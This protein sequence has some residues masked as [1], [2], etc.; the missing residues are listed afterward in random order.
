MRLHF[1]RGRQFGLQPRHDGVH[2]LQREDHIAAPVEE[3]IDLGRAAAGNRLNFLQT[4]HAVDGFF[5]MTRDSDEHLVDGHDSVINADDDAG[6]IGIRENGNR[7]R[8]SEISAD[9]SQSND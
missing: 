3:E 5:E 8:E 9:Q 4:R 6:K 2:T 1:G 7:N